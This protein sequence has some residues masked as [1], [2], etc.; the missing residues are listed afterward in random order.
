MQRV[1]IFFFFSLLLFRC[2]QDR[3]RY[4]IATTVNGILGSLVS[5]TGI[6]TL[7]RPWEALVIGAVASVVS[8]LSAI[9]LWKLR[10]DDP[11]GVIPV[12]LF[13]GVWALLAIGKDKV[14]S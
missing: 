3:G 14:T 10:I 2:L 1:N 12:H 5:I 7:C 4:D 13:C 8:S 11:V 9:L 6:C